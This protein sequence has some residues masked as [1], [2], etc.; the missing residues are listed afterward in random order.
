MLPLR[1][2]NPLEAVHQLRMYSL[3]TLANGLDILTA[4]S[5][6]VNDYESNGSGLR[7]CWGLPMLPRI[8]YKFTMP[9]G[10]Y[11]HYLDFSPD[12]WTASR[13]MFF[14]LGW[15]HPHDKEGRFSPGKG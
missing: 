7:H 10:R 15:F 3:R 11:S 5:A 4:V 8:P 12:E 9:G 6:M 1:I 13:A 2:P 14:S